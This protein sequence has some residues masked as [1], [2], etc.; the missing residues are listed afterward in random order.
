MAFS[1]EVSGETG[2]YKPNRG[3]G[4]T[5]R[6]SQTTEE[7]VIHNMDDFHHILLSSVSITEES[8]LRHNILE[9]K[10]K[11]EVAATVREVNHI[12][13]EKAKTVSARIVSDIMSNINK[14]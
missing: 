14:E 6:E 7:V 12:D 4:R 2:D 9:K 1:N 5:G 13:Y 8:A 3:S 11:R 10:R